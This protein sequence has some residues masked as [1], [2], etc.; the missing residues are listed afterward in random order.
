MAKYKIITDLNLKPVSPTPPVG[1]TIAMDMRPAVKIPYGTI[2]EGDVIKKPS[3]G[4]MQVFTQYLQFKYNGNTFQTMSGYSLVSDTPTETTTTKYYNA[5]VNVAKYGYK[6]GEKIKVYH[7]NMFDGMLSIVA[8]PETY[9]TVG[10]N[11]NEMWNVGG[12]TQYKDITLGTEIPASEIEKK[13]GSTKSSKM[14][15][16]AILLIVIA[17][18][19]GLYWVLSRP[20]K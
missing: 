20:S 19:I 1:M 5:T 14:S 3:N 18:S 11:N 7:T 8:K 10:S 9:F 4:M 13:G 12:F 16:T 2:V 15:D 17:A 6:V